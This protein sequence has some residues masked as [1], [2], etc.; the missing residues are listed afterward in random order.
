[1]EAMVGEAMSPALSY[2]FQALTNAGIFLY[3]LRE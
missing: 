2:S 1:M 3:M